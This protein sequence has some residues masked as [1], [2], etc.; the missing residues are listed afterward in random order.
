MLRSEP[1]TLFVDLWTV[2]RLLSVL[3]RNPEYRGTISQPK[4]ITSVLKSMFSKNLKP[5]KV[6]CWV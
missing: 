1:V 4:K 6:K 5:D 2:L 3:P